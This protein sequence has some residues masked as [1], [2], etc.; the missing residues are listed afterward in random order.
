VLAERDVK[1]LYRKALAGE[2][3]HFTGVDDPYEPPLHPEVTCHTDGRETPEQSAEKIL[4]FAEARGW[5][6]DSA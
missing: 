3:S 6:T 4:N 1:G 2:V 5:L